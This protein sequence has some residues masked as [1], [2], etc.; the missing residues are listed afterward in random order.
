MF[1]TYRKIKTAIFSCVQ[2][3]H[4]R[5]EY[6]VPHAPLLLDQHLLIFL[7]VSFSAVQILLVAEQRFANLHA[8][9]GSVLFADA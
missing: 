5:T 1:C 3:K 2:M 7:F 8:L 4:L 6:L 9:I